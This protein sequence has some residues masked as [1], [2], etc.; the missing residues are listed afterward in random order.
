MVRYIDKVLAYV[1]RGRELLIFAHTAFPAAGLQ[2]PGGTVEPGETPLAA[3]ARELE[4]ETGLT[5]FRIARLLGIVEGCF[6]A[7]DQLRFTRRHFY[8]VIPTV[9]TPERWRHWERHASDGAGYEFEL[10]WVPLPDGVP[11]LAGNQ[12]ALLSEL[13]C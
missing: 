3:V 6:R 7:D 9:P 8:H 11:P 5:A 10:F 13:L 12:A 2:V 1:T 4:E